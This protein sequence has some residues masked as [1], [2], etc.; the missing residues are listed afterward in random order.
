MQTPC[1]APVA[2]GLRV[3][4]RAAG[5]AAAAVRLLRQPGLEEQCFRLEY[6]GGSPCVLADSDSGFLYGLL[7]LADGF[8]GKWDARPYTGRPRIRQRGIKFN[9]P[10]DARTPSYSDASDSAFENIPQVWSWDFWTEYL[11]TMAENRFNVLSLWS[12]SPFPGLVR[13]PEY[14]ELALEDVFRSP[15]P[16]RPEMSGARMWTPDMA[17]TAYPVLKMTV[18]EK[19]RFWQRVMEYARDRCIRVYLITWNLFAYGTEGNACGIDDDQRNPETARYVYCAVRALLE[20]YPLLAGIGVTAGEHM[21]GDETDVP[22]LRQTYGRAVEDV[23][24]CHPGRTVTF[25]HRMQ[26]ARYEEVRQAYADFSQPFFVSFKYAQAHLNSP[27]PGFFREFLKN[28]P[29]TERFFLTLREDDGYLYRRCDEAFAAQL[30]RAIPAER[31]EGFCWGADGFTWGRDYASRRDGHPLYLQKMWCS[32]ALMGA[33]AYDPY[34]A[35]GWLLPRLCRRFRLEPEEGRALLEAFTLASGVFPLINAVHWRDYDFQ[36]YPEGCCRFLH[37]PVG[38]LVFSDIL[39]FMECPAM[40]HT[41][42]ISVA[43]EAA[44]VPAAQ[45]HTPSWAA[46]RLWEIFN[47]VPALL[48]DLP[49]GS[50]TPEVGETLADMQALALLAGYYARKLEAALLLCRFRR[51][52]DGALRT[53]GTA[54]L[55]QAAG[56]WSAYSAHA[57]RRFYPQ[58]MTRMGGMRVDFQAFDRAAQ[59]DAELAAHMEPAEAPPTEEE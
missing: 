24:K 19:I 13:I 12:L 51:E 54:L 16:P 30:F 47:R 17:Q 9:I 27:V 39:E 44:G 29:P 55:T 10:L 8:A 49:F 46:S 18:E 41:P 5:E 38:K 34:R 43:Q 2:F 1:S 37:P 3:L 40:P 48:R 32:A 56:L 23:C 35:P 7:E 36:W 15:T 11:D 14:P 25:L 53:R 50:R 20:T 42:W 58:R 31:V 52:G 33:M 4:E 22:F 59:L 26:Y 45:E 57:A 21:A 28:A 6:S